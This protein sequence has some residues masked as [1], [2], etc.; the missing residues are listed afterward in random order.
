MNAGVIAEQ[1][2]VLFLMMAMGYGA[3]KRRLVSR[4]G[5]KS[6]SALIVNILNP[7]LVLSGVL[8]K[9]ITYSTRMLVENLG[10]VVLMFLILM[11]LG[12]VFVRITRPHPDVENT[13]R[14][15]TI[16]PNLGFMGI[17]LVSSVYGETSVIFVAFY[18][19][20]YNLL[21]YSYG[22]ILSTGG[23]NQGA[24]FPVRKLINPGMASCLAAIVIFAFHI[25]L[26]EAAGTFFGYMGNAAVAMSMM[27]VGMT[28]A[29]SDLKRAFTDRHLLL[30]TLFSLLLIPAVCIPLL[31]LLP[32]D[33]VSYG[34]FILLISM[35][36]GSTVTL[37]EM[38]Y[39]GSDGTVSASG[40]ALTSLVSMVT[41]PLISMLA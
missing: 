8:N 41:I 19:V 16:F 17:P 12:L 25:R 5:A 26:P 32:I 34:I 36:V 28:V 30:F 14:L 3:F 38:E 11:I 2:A 33:P 20:G 6:L 21:I 7:C 37:V 27:A 22:I 9:E 15:M 40:I 10:L 23:L 24:G 31:R 39:G 1:M 18:I 35:P 4:E 13:Y 29:Q